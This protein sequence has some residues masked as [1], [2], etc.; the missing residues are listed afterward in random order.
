MQE[1]GGRRAL[2]FQQVAAFPQMA[3]AGNSV[4]EMLEFINSSG[5]GAIGTPDAC[6]AQIERLWQQSSGES[7]PRPV[8]CW[9][10]NC[11][12]SRLVCAR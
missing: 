5:L 12:Q 10:G 4:G 3:V 9:R 7:G 2:Y 11:T 8:L 6:T 1:R